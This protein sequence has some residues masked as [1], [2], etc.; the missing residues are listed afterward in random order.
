MEDVWQCEVPKDGPEDINEH[1]C[2]TSPTACLMSTQ[3]HEE[4]WI[5]GWMLEK[6]TCTAHKGTQGQLLLMLTQDL[7]QGP[8]DSTG[9]G[10]GKRALMVWV[11]RFMGKRSKPRYRNRKSTNTGNFISE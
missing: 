3:E 8:S 7:P 10:N 5:Q 11:P 1:D 6:D 4:T 9:H 2:S